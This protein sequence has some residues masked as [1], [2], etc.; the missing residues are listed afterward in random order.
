ML[1]SDYHHEQYV[2]SFAIHTII[3]KLEKVLYELILSKN[4]LY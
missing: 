3:T 4:E 1:T 2:P